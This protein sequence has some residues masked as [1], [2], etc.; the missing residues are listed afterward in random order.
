MHLY[1]VL[2]GILLLVALISW[3]KVNAFLA[4]LVV[5]I[6]TGLLLGI[7]FGTIIQSVYK[8]IGDTL[9]Q[10][11]IVIVLGAMLGKIV[12][13]S[14]A[15][16][17]IATYMMNIFGEK[18]IQWALMV[19]G[20]IIGIPLFYN[21]GFVLM[22]P[23]IFSVVYKYKLPAVYIGLPMLA[24]LSVTHGFLP[25]HP[26]PAA[27]VGQFHANMGKTLLYGM[28]IAIPAVILAGLVYSKTLK[29]IVSSPLQGLVAAEK[30]EAELPG[31]GNSLLTSLLPVI[32]L[33]LTTLLPLISHESPALQHFLA[34]AGDPSIILL[35]AIA[36]AT[37]TLGIRCGMTM[38]KIMHIYESAVKDVAVIL[39]I[40]A[41]A[42]ALKQV[43]TDSGVSKEIAS[44]L[45]VWP[46]HPLVLGWLMAAII[47]VCLGSATVAGLTAAGL[48]LPLM[49]RMH[50][51][52]NL[53]VL[54]VGAGSLMFSHVN[55]SGFWLFK[56]YFN[57][58]IKDTIRSWSIME[59]IV[60]V[61]GLAG[62]LSLN[63]L[64]G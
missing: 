9:G 31:I 26:A 44:Y 1:I 36:F 32:L 47:R 22:V 46:I 64:V 30:P 61:V 12:A 57:L 41:G 34:F 16:Q 18:Y 13:E 27:L 58:S 6:V 54:S 52:P 11:A 2:F 23:L 35:L 5:S 40:V 17:R 14:G 42:G 29:G 62:V 45:Q 59:T 8:G 48:I 33:M 50:V 60:S 38:T 7:S 49:N 63:L 3:G 53:M 19:T 51:D 4:F 28:T 55:D 10:L 20:F 21:V 24:S 25:P 56:E 37:Y 39:L 43:F 15:A